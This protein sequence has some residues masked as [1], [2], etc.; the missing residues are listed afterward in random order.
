MLSKIPH[1]AKPVIA[2]VALILAAVV[3]FFALRPEKKVLDPMIIDLTNGQVTTMSHDAYTKYA[4]RAGKERRK[5][6]VEATGNGGL[7][8]H[9]RFRTDFDGQLEYY[10]ISKDE[11]S[12][13]LDFSAQPGP[14]VRD[15]FVPGWARDIEPAHS[16]A[17]AGSSGAEESRPR[18]RQ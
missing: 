12:Q 7:V 2:I 11:V 18:D 9:N 15:E 5:F 17:N 4:G 8:I 14:A 1:Q 13:Y 3:L 6:P 10:G 16:P